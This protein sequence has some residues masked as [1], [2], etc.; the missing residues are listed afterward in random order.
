VGRQI[1]VTDFIYMEKICHYSVVTSHYMAHEQC[2]P[3]VATVQG[4]KV[5][6]Q[7][8]KVTQRISST[9]AISRPQMVTSNWNMVEIIIV[10]AKVWQ[11]S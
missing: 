10:E 11:A 4:Q 9:C 6:G 2:Q 8:R 3:C 1:W 5:K 7:G